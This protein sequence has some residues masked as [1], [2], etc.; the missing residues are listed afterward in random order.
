MSLAIILLFLIAC[1]F[2]LLWIILCPFSQFF[3]LFSVICNL[4]S[5]IFLKLVVYIIPT[6]VRSMQKMFFFSPHSFGNIGGI[7]IPNSHSP[8]PP[9]HTWIFSR[10]SLICKSYLQKFVLLNIKSIGV[11]TFYF[12]SIRICRF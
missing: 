9:T 1:W 4:L 6:L 10:P 12:M 3:S 8:R 11:W 5:R 2:Y 7:N